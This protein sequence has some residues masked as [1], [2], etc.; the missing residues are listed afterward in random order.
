MKAKNMA[1]IYSSLFGGCLGAAF[2]NF[3]NNNTTMGLI[4][5]IPA[6]VWIIPITLAYLA[7]KQESFADKEKVNP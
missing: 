5:I 6:C 7:A 1:L 3:I 4:W 2:G